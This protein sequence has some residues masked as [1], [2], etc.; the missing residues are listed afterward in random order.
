[1][2]CDIVVVWWFN[3]LRT[4]NE[5]KERV[6]MLY[7]IAMGRTASVVA[8][9]MAQRMAL[10]PPPRPRGRDAPLPTIMTPKRQS[11]NAGAVHVLTMR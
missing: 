4:S 9:G 3:I 7:A 6:I 5:R 2:L 1:M 10:L 11:G 8:R